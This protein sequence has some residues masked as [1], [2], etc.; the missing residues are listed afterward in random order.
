ML[1]QTHQC[2]LMRVFWAPMSVSRRGY[3][4]WP[5]FF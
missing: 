3:F 1:A 2:A 4:C 5:K